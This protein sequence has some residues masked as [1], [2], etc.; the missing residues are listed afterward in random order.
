MYA[1]IRAYM[2]LY[3]KGAYRHNTINI[4]ARLSRL[5]HRLGNIHACS[6]QICKRSREQGLRNCAAACPEVPIIDWM[7]HRYPHAL[8]ASWT[9][10]MWELQRLSTERL[11]IPTSTCITNRALPRPLYSCLQST[12]N[13]RAVRVTTPEQTPDVQSS[14]TP[15]LKLPR[16]DTKHQTS[17]SGL[18]R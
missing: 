5:E 1:H 8:P 7:L 4:H 15:D 9:I 12:C 13:S 2:G 10:H 3:Q 6:L 18:A 17:T 14:H 11:V 16:G